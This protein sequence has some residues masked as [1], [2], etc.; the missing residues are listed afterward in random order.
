MSNPITVT[1]EGGP[2]DGRALK[3]TEDTDRD[4]VRIQTM[5]FG[6]DASAKNHVYRR[7]EGSDPPV[8]RHSGEEK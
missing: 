3:F 6:P 8:F 5:S 1:L 4:I 2:A 7:V